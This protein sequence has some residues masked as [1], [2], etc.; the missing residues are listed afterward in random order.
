QALGIVVI[1]GLSS[2]LA[3]TLVLVPV[4]YMWLAPERLAPTDEVPP[5]ASPGPP[6]SFQPSKPETPQPEIAARLK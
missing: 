2:S 3:L 1:G 6:I 4:V 5:P